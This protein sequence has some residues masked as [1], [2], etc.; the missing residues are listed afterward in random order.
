MGKVRKQQRR[1]RF[2][3]RGGGH[4][5]DPCPAM[6]FDGSVTSHDDM[7]AGTRVGR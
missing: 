6:C 3:S 7:S 5:A 2:E 4:A 1:E